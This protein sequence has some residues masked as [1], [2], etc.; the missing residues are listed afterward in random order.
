M[1]GL[2]VE[3]Y[4]QALRYSMENGIFATVEESLTYT[5]RKVSSWSH[6]SAFV[7]II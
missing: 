5:S 4:N 7:A 2:V 3:V 6:P 1:S